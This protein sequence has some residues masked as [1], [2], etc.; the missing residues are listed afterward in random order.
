MAEKHRVSN[1]ARIVTL[2]AVIAVLMVI[3]VVVVVLGNARPAPPPGQVLAP[4]GAQGPPQYDHDVDAVAPA[5]VP[6]P[7]PPPQAADEVRAQL[8]QAEARRAALR[9][10]TVI[11]NAP[12]PVR[13]GQTQRIEVRASG[14]EER[15]AALNA[16]PSSQPA[17]QEQPIKIGMTLRAQLSGD[18]FETTLL[19]GEDSARPSLRGDVPEWVWD[20][21]ATKPGM[22]T[23]TLTVRSYVGSDEVDAIRY[24]HRPIRVERDWGYTVIN[25][26][27]SPA[28]TATGITVPVIL[29]GIG[30]VWAS[31]RRRRKKQQAG[32]P[33][34]PPS[35]P[36][37]A[38][39]AEQSPSTGYL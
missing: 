10:G 34:Q 37:P 2:A 17:P 31:V 16:F 25:L 18:G 29:G 7:A 23:L 27:G 35:P 12:D 22:R 20:V 14:I 11:Y 28:W 13:Q 8:E 6:A 33:P 4:V 9:E 15:L 38:E 39:K 30:A 21:R 26:L 19:G 5:A 3:S 1:R 32:E 24:V 36:Q